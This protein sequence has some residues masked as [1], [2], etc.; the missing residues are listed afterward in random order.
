MRISSQEKEKLKEKILIEA[1]P[2][3]KKF[4]ND[5]APVDKIMKQVGLTSGALYSH[6]KSKE[7]FF[8]QVLLR[9]MHDLNDSYAAEVKEHG[10][11]A[12]QHL[13]EGYLSEE[14]V[15][16]VGDGCVFA[17]LGMDL[18]RQKPSTR[19]IYEQKINERL[20]LFARVLPHG[21]LEERIDKMRLIFSSLVGTMILARSMKN[22]EEIKKLLNS[23]KRQLLSFI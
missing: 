20:E 11:K 13:I 22:P 14:H 6:F 21:T 10:A 9:E 3:L 18:H 23:T 2:F 16:N 1:L 7:D 4:G 8:A 12:V 17:A 15:K 19:T 5:G